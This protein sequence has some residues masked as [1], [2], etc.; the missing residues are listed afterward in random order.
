HMT[1]AEVAYKV[2]F[3]TPQYLTTVFKQL[4]GI[5]P[6]QYRKNGTNSDKK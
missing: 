3:G 1:I 2:G 6:S 5:S 4:Y